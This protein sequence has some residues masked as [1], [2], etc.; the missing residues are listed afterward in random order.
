MPNISSE[1]RGT[2]DTPSRN[3]AWKNIALTKSLT[4]CFTLNWKWADTLWRGRS[5]TEWPLASFILWRNGHLIQCPALQKKGVTWYVFRLVKLRA[6]WPS[7]ATCLMAVCVSCAG[8]Q[9][10]GTVHTCD[11]DSW[12]KY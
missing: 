10:V 3:P 2:P 6:L 1:F 11:L 4:S 5:V 8:V 9:S 7:W 12:Q